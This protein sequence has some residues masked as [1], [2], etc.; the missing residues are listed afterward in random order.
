MKEW[1]AGTHGRRKYVTSANSGVVD[2]VVFGHDLDG[3][4]EQ[5]EL[6]EDPVFWGTSGMSANL[7]AIKNTLN[8][9]KSRMHMPLEY[10]E[11]TT[12]VNDSSVDE[13]VFGRDMDGSG[14]MD[15]ASGIVGKMTDHKEKL[16]TGAAGSK[17]GDLNNM[18]SKLQSRTR[19]R[20]YNMQSAVVD[21]LLYGHDLDPSDVTKDEILEWQGGVA[22]KSSIGRNVDAQ[23]GQDRKRI[24]LSRQG[25]A[26]EVLSAPEGMIYSKNSVA[27]INSDF[28]DMQLKHGAAGLSAMRAAELVDREVMHLDGRGRKAKQSRKIKSADAA[29]QMVKN[30]KE[31]SLVTSHSQASKPAQLRTSF[32]RGQKPKGSYGKA[33]GALGRASNDG[34]EVAAAMGSTDAYR[35]ALSAGQALLSAPYSATDQLA[36][37]LK[38]RDT[39][40]YESGSRELYKARLAEHA[41]DAAGNFTKPEDLRQIE[42]VRPE[43]TTKYSPFG[44][45]PITKASNAA[46]F[47]TSASAVSS[48]VGAAPGANAPKHLAD[49]K[50]V[51]AVNHAWPASTAM[52][53]VAGARPRSGR[54]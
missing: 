31:A 37:D 11:K 7:H 41:T 46:R 34:S 47:Q 10:Y 2:D 18:K 39:Q 22:G 48:I 54:R 19:S 16:F 43:V 20:M 9:P 24:S 23:T 13:V 33:S 29:G 40:L 36:A 38:Q 32:E 51:P 27:K 8:D 28:A 1:D 44:I 14:L 5:K 21:E 17:S 52:V 49:R 26:V 4:A 6:T 15:E 3:S 12:S 50:I 53:P 42:R 25:D 30:E 35:Q 45:E